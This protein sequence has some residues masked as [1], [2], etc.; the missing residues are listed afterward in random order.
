MDKKSKK[1]FSVLLALMILICMTGCAGKG[2]SSINMVTMSEKE[3]EASLSYRS[4][5]LNVPDNVRL[6]KILEAGNNMY[7]TINRNQSFSS[8]SYTLTAFDENNIIYDIVIS[9]QSV[10]ENNETASDIYVNADNSVSILFTGNNENRILSVS[11]DGSIKKNIDISPVTSGNVVSGLV[12][13]P[14]GEYAVDSGY[15]TV[16]MFSADGSFLYDASVRDFPSGVISSG[17]DIVS[18]GEPFVYY[19]YINTKS[20]EFITEVCILDRNSRRFNKSQI[21]KDHTVFA[22]TGEYLFC[23]ASDTG[24]SGIR[25]DGSSVLLI[26]LLNIGIDS[27]SIKSVR[28]FEDGSFIL[29]IYDVFNTDANGFV[30]IS[31]SEKSAS[32]EKK[33][34]TLGCFEIP[35]DIKKQI[36][37]F[38]RT[39][40]EYVIVVSSFAEN[41]DEEYETDALIEFNKQLISG[42]IP[43]I[44]I[45]NHEMP[46]DGYIRKGLFTDLYPYLDND[47]EIG[48]DSF[49]EN[50]LKAGE[51]NGKLY[52]M[53]PTFYAETYVAKGSVVGN[54]KLLTMDKAKTLVSEM[55]DGTAAITLLSRS[56]ALKEAVKYSNLIDFESGTSSFDS[57][58]FI[59]L[60]TELKNL[61]ETLEKYEPD[62]PE[63]IERELSYKNGKTL[64][65]PFSSYGF[66]FNHRIRFYFE[67]DW[68]FVSFPTCSPKTNCVMYISERLAVSEQ[69]QN[70]EGAWEFIKYAMTHNLFS[71]Q[72][73][74]YNENGEEI[75]TDDYFYYLLSGFPSYKPELY[76]L[77]ETASTPWHDYDENGNMVIKKQTDVFLGQN[78][79]YGELTEDE[80]SDFIELIKGAESTDKINSQILVI[81][82]EESERFFHNEIDADEAAKNI[83]SRM[84]IYMSENYS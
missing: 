49:F 65:M 66:L 55:G 82:T 22:G 72:Y 14:D 29:G 31:P 23:T 24:I 53:F 63:Y 68:E 39:N 62:S 19:S 32:G 50:I 57:T 9:D 79:E 37:D 34:V 71:S 17:T 3:I 84:D 83:Q 15:G 47:S 56:D 1:I 16:F 41:I 46:L 59:T 26:N 18:T 58:D 77:A 76:T 33:V 80:V 74:Y 54:E 12:V 6:G 30:K 42:N 81:I 44:V 36:A 52:S 75:I 35:V 13:T 78:M 60:L 5:Y 67:D 20:G 38:N 10:A 4:N 70:K 7:F 48:R 2:S 11:A 40:D 25:A 27:D 43:D 51:N 64:V 73:T 45:I 21:V 61:P 69:S 8:V 28:F